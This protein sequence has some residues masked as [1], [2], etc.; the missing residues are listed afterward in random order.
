MKIA[1]INEE[2][3]L[4][5]ETQKIDLEYINSEEFKKIIDDMTKTCIEA[6][7]A[8]LSAN[9]VNINKRFFIYFNKDKFDVIINPVIKGK[10]DIITHYNERC[11]S[12]PGLKFNIKRYKTLIIECLNLDG[13]TVILKSPNKL[14]SFIW[15]H[16]IDH[17]NG[18]LLLD[19][20]K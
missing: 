5:V 6:N 1:T 9:Q 17:L 11:L 7:G 13:K 18:I 4:S 8:G 10:K 16:E 3:I 19:R 2:N 15:Q 20:R 12:I 14:I